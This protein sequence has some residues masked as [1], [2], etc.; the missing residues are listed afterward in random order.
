MKYFKTEQGIMKKAIHNLDLAIKLFVEDKDY[1]APILLAGAAEDDLRKLLTKENKKNALDEIKETI[2]AETKI[3][4][5]ESADILNTT[6]NWL[7]HGTVNGVFC[8]T[9]VYDEELESVQY[10]IRAIDNFRRL[11]GGIKSNHLDFLKLV[12][13]SRCSELLDN[14]PIDE[15]KIIE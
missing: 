3:T 1:T 8:K 9:F 11:F 7:K 5:Q 12:K 15:I 13:V 10:I 2:L 14:I 4:P 6:K